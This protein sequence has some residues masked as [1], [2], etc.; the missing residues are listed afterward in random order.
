[1]KVPELSR[2]NSGTPVL[3]FPAGDSPLFLDEGIQNR[4][5]WSTGFFRFFPDFSFVRALYKNQLSERRED[6][7]FNIFIM[8]ANDVHV[9]F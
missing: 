3:E 5:M 7:E 1:V 2:E 8:G 4:K 9:D 6:N